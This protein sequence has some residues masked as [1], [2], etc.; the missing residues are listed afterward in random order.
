MKSKILLLISTFVFASFIAKAS[1][2]VTT[3]CGA[4][5]PGKKEDIGGSVHSDAKKPLKDVSITAY[6]SS[7]KEKVVITDGCGSFSFDDLKAG[8][9]KF[10]FEKQGYRKVV[11]ENVSVK[12]DEAFQ[13]SIEM[14][15][16]SE[17]DILPS[18]MHFIYN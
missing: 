16:D 5:T 11:K 8:N 15:Q 3:K 17:Q 6:L 14:V 10:V 4:P 9:Y 7:K 1:D 13:L 12:V 2:N 18:P